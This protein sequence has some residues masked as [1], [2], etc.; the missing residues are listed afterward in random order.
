MLASTRLLDTAGICHHGIAWCE[1]IKLVCLT[2]QGRRTVLCKASA[3]HKTLPVC[4]V[5]GSL[6]GATHD[7]ASVHNKVRDA[8]QGE[9]CKTM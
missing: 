5:L 1:L 9:T 4:R 6:Y 2:P 3:A 8:E 7:T